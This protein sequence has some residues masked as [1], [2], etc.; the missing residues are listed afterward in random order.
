MAERPSELNEKLSIEDDKKIMVGTLL[1]RKPA[2][3]LTI[4]KRSKLKLPMKP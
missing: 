4:P 3:L 2:N 1:I